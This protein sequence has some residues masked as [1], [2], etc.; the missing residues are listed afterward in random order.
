MIP[1][2]DHRGDTNRM[3]IIGLVVVRVSQAVAP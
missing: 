2:R 1:T 3:P